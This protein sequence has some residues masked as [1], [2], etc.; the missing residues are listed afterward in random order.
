M[1]RPYCLPHP[2]HQI[3]SC[4]GAFPYL[5]MS[6]ADFLKQTPSSKHCTTTTGMLCEPIVPRTASHGVFG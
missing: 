6:R 2:A 4:P 5:A 1:L 3:A